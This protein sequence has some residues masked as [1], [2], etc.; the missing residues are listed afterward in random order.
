MGVDPGQEDDIISSSEPPKKRPSP[1]KAAPEPAADPKYQQGWPYADPVDPKPDADI[2]GWSSGLAEPPKKHLS[3]AKAEK[4]DEDKKPE[5]EDD[6]NKAETSESKDEKEDEVEEAPAKQDPKTAEP[7]PALDGYPSSNGNPPNLQ[8]PASEAM[9]DQPVEATEEEAK[10]NENK[11]AEVKEEVKE[12][13][14][15]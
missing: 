6:G 11:P 7:F 1:S 2:M 8:P 3:S 15:K 10:A 14:S 5:K 9:K 12:G 4:M 13:E